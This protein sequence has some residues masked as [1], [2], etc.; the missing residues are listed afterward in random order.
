MRLQLSIYILQQLSTLES[1]CQGCK[2]KLF[3]DTAMEII[4]AAGADTDMLAADTGSTGTLAA[5]MDKCCL[6]PSVFFG[7]WCE[8]FSLRQ[9]H[10]PVALVSE[11]TF[12]VYSGCL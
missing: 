7:G 8:A 6:T 10:Q 11:K 2:A 1:A 9:I 12:V 5:C 3:S 4:T